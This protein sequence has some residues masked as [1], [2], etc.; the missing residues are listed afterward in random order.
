MIANLKVSDDGYAFQGE[1][2]FN[3]FQMDCLVYIGEGVSIEYAEKCIAMLDNL[4][5]KTVDRICGACVRY[6]EDFR[7]FF[8]EEDMAIP[9][10][11]SGKAILQYVKPLRIFI[12]QPPEK[13]KTGCSIELNCD[14]EPEHGMEWTI[15]EGEIKYVGPFEANPP[16]SERLAYS[17]AHNLGYQ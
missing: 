17:V 7:A 8:K 16:F 5:G 6:C 9:E 12:S 14:W 11:V 13:G 2:W 4:S 1:V 15:E 3:L 10:G